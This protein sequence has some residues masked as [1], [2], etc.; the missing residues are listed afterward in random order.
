MEYKGYY[1][2]HT[3]AGLNARSTSYNTTMGE[4]WRTYYGITYPQTNL[5]PDGDKLKNWQEF[6][7][8]YDSFSIGTRLDPRVGYIANT[9]FDYWYSN[10]TKITRY[11]YT[12]WKTFYTN[13]TA[14]ISNSSDIDGDKVLDWQEFYGYWTYTSPSQSAWGLD[15]KSKIY[16][17]AIGMS[18]DWATYYGISYDT[19]GG[20][21]DADSDGVKNKDEY[22]ANSN[23][24]N[25]DTDKDDLPDK[26]EIKW[27]LEPNNHHGTNGI[28]GKDGDHDG[29]GITN[30][31]EL[32]F[33]PT[34][35]GMN[36]CSANTDGDGHG[37]YKE[38]LLY[39]QFG[40][41]IKHSDGQ[42]VS[43]IVANNNPVYVEM[44]DPTS[45]YTLHAAGVSSGGGTYLDASKTRNSIWAFTWAL[46]P[47]TLDTYF[48]G[49][50]ASFLT[51]TTIRTLISSTAIMHN[52]MP[53]TTNRA[54]QGLSN[55]IM[56]VSL[57]NGAYETINIISGALT[58]AQR[59]TWV[60]SNKLIGTTLL[61]A[62]KAGNRVDQI[63][64]YLTVSWYWTASGQICTEYLGVQYSF[65]GA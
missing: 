57:S 47:A 62:V 40:N 30:Y 22:A 39:Y 56:K 64:Q 50:S 24:Q 21:A 60:N 49:Y 28:E 19:T 20:N 43:P 18:K 48:A 32:R 27:G 9:S 7:G 16:D 38:Y 41:G 8:K 13:T 61:N 35:M 63:R 31:Q 46:G 65:N 34:N 55:W 2:D 23:P 3:H 25:P 53:Y 54:S 5:D 42:Q 33:D 15:P 59:C 6:R 45:W 17:A 12:D 51:N 29:D 1:S 11:W 37:D 44:A 4:D 52:I 10:D 36:P 58:Y 14:V 26:Y